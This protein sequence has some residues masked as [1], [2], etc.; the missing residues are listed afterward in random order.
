[1]QL[2]QIKKPFGHWDL[3]VPKGFGNRAGI[4][5]VGPTVPEIVV[6]G[7]TMALGTSESGKGNTRL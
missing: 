4:R 7:E 1:M 3:A 2:A 6:L 5:N